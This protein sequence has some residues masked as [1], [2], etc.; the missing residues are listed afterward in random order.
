MVYS[1]LQ[2]VNFK[3]GPGS[4]VQVD[5]GEG[6]ISIGGV[7]LYVVTTVPLHPDLIPGPEPYYEGVAALDPLTRVERVCNSIQL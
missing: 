2:H 1:L 3:V 6:R 4:V 5:T 7:A